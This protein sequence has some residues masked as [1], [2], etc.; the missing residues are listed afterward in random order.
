MKAL[1]SI[2]V[3]LAAL[4]GAT[5]ASAEPLDGVVTGQVANGT[6]GGTSPAGDTAVLLVFSVS[7]QAQV[8][9][10]SATVGDDGTFRFDGV[11]RDPNLA[12]FVL[13]QHQ[14]V[15]YPSSQPFQLRDTT[16]QVV[17]VRVFDTTT[18]PDALVLERSNLLLIDQ[19]PGMLSLLQMGAMV[20][21]G[22]RTYVT[23]NPQDLVLARGIQFPLPRGAM[24]ARLETGFRNEDVLSSAD[25]IQVTT[26]LKPGRQEFAL[27]FQLPYTGS[28]AD[29]SLRVPYP[30]G[31]FSVYVPENG[32]SV[33]S[34][35][36]TSGSRAEM[37]GRSFG[38]FGASN[39]G[40]NARVSA[41]LENLTWGGGSGL[42]PNQLTLVSLGVVIF[43]LSA[44]VLVFGSRW[45]GRSSAAQPAP[46]TDPNQERL[47]LLVRLASLDERYESGELSSEQYRHERDHGK[48][49][50]LELTRA[51]RGASA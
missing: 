38:V 8:D 39:V 51:Q 18:S 46:A 17:E 29:L 16:E 33:R 22:D 32:P 44:G 25:G 28:S 35:L 47:E 45:R 11:D 48:A 13:V 43:A 24:G 42:S 3:L 1:L 20:N 49:R 37:G 40:R 2:G 50:L 26:P 6:N 27:S 12:Y 14:G 5:G 7:Q 36:L 34:D 19:E 31:Q 41:R 10:K 30:A 23:E 15:T 9:E 4:F 21:T